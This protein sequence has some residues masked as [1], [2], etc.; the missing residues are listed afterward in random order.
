MNPSNDSIF[1][2]AKHLKA[3]SRQNQTLASSSKSSPASLVVPDRSVLDRLP[4][5]IIFIPDPD[6]KPGTYKCKSCD[7]L[8]NSE[9]QMQKVLLQRNKYVINVCRLSS[10]PKMICVRTAYI[11]L[12][13]IHI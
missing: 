3:T 1:T 12:S 9:S 6:K 4:A 5:S 7:T 13:L 2:G 8:L 11:D 10:M